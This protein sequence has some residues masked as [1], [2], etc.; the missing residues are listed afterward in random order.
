MPTAPRPSTTW[1]PVLSDRETDKANEQEGRLYGT[2]RRSATIWSLPPPPTIFL[3]IGGGFTLRRYPSCSLLMLMT[4]SHLSPVQLPTALLGTHW[5][6]H[7]TTGLPSLLSGLSACYFG[8]SMA[9]P[10]QSPHFLDGWV[11]YSM[12]HYQP[13]AVLQGH[14]WNVL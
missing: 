10:S 1:S 5:G 7:R 3:S 4:A 11:Y 12:G 13:R 2:I 6:P 14:G 9:H 8:L